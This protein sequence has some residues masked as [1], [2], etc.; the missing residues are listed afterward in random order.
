MDERVQ[1][2]LFDLTVPPPPVLP[3]GAQWRTVN[4]PLQPIGFV[5]QRTRRRTI[6]FVVDDTGLR[7][8]A[9][10]WAT[11]A[12][13]DQAVAGRAPW[14]LEKL[15]LRHQRLEQHATAQ[16][17]WAQHG[18]IPYMGCH[19][20]LELCTAQKEARFSGRPDVPEPGDTLS[21]P[22]PEQASEQRIQDSV[23][24]WLQRQARWWFGL[25]LQHFLEIS[26][27]PLHSWRLS[28]AT[29]RWG[30][31]TSARRI[32]LNWR[33]IHFN[34]DVID[35]VIAHEVAHLREMNHSPAFWREVAR[36][37]PHYAPARLELKRHRP[38]VLPLL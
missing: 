26:G 2:R 20:T 6:G 22:L 30:S 28:A 1:L 29:T 3:D 24:A 10:H 34:H 31:C 18:R 33:L 7:V 14:I 11:L 25:R 8:T 32:L 21:L 19:I 9:P 15:Q 36:L 16:R 17:L 13:V 38:G 37:M 5:L 35:Y 23:H 27:Q 4:T 12:Q